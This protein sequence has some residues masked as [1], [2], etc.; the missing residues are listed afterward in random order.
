[1]EGSTSAARQSAHDRF[2]A[3]DLKDVNVLLIDPPRLV[4][5][6]LEERLLLLL[7]RLT[8]FRGT[9]GAE[10]EVFFPVSDGRAFFDGDD[11]R[12]VLFRLDERVGE[13]WTIVDDVDVV[14]VEMIDVC[15]LCSIVRCQQRLS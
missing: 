15:C 4:A 12:E 2:S 9:A 10:K 3:V 13:S 6:L 5:V 11:G 1:L 8:A 14:S 7:V